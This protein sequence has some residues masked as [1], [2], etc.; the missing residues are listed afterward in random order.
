MSR[1]EINPVKTFANVDAADVVELLY[2]LQNA[3]EVAVLDMQE[4]RAAV[5]NLTG[6]MLE[7]QRKQQ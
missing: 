4:Y 6:T 5:A 2:E 1:A 7:Q 3:I